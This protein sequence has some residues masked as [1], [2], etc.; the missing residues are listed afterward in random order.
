MLATHSRRGAPAY[1]TWGFW[2]AH[3]ATDLKAMVGAIYDQLQA[4]NAMS[5]FFNICDGKYASIAGQVK[6][7]K[8]AAAGNAGAQAGSSRGGS[9]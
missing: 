1:F 7:E 2:T 6:Q 9:Y 5:W 4:N 8:E 3:S